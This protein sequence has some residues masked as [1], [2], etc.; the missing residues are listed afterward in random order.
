MIKEHGFDG[1]GLAVLLGLYNEAPSSRSLY[2]YSRFSLPQDEVITI[3]DLTSRPLVIEHAVKVASALDRIIKLLGKQDDLKAFLEDV[4]EAHKMLNVG[5]RNFEKIEDILSRAI[6][7]SLGPMKTD[8]LMQS[9][10]KACGVMK[11]F[12]ISVY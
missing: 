8:D 10:D 4:G 3:E 5:S 12:I 9:W 7:E 11:Q 1:V 6:G 2:G